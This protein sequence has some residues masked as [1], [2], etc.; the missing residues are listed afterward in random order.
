MKNKLA[1]ILLLPGFFLLS[2]APKTPQLSRITATELDYK[3][4]EFDYL[5]GKGKINYQDDSI[6]LSAT[7][8]LRIKKDSVIWISFSKKIELA[9]G[10]ITQDS[11][12]FLDRWHKVYY[13]YN[14]EDLSKKFNF[15]IDYQLIQ[16]MII[17][18]LTMPIEQNEK[19]DQQGNFFHV[20]QVNGNVVVDNYIN[21]SMMK[22]E[23]VE[24]IE[25][26]TKNSLSLNYGDFQLVDDTTPFPFSGIVFLNY[27]NADEQF[28]T[29]IAFTYDKA[30]FLV[31]KELKLPFNIPEKYDRQ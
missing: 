17:G 18:E 29:K 16:S 11:I 26:P 9:R 30:E 22:V 5:K 20:R 21:K 24:M 2:C 14:F 15:K 31:D 28:T 23:R 27:I 13:V 4:L 1:I 19:I 12:V 3:A 8:N 25:V 6:R 10:I 7:A